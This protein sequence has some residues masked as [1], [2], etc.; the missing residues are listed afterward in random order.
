MSNVSNV[1]ILLVDRNIHRSFPDCQVSRIVRIELT[2]NNNRIDPT[3]TLKRYFAYYFLLTLW[4]FSIAETRI[5]QGENYVK[6]DL[7]KRVITQEHSTI[8]LI[9]RRAQ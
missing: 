5:L 1:F 4:H 3:C 2:A 6:K 7:T 9:L 8:D